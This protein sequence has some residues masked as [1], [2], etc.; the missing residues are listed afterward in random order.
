[1]GLSSRA[2]TGS[3]PCAALMVPFEVAPGEQ[4]EVVFLLGQAGTIEQVRELL[5][6]YKQTGSAGR[7]LDE[8]RRNWD[9][10]L[11]VVQVRTPDDALN[12]LLNRWLL[13]QTLSCRVWGRSAFYQSSGAYGFRDQLQDVLALA[14]AAPQLTREQILRA[15]GH[16]FVEGDV[17]HWWHPPG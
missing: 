8:A 9:Q 17:Q 16:Q 4:A 15:S 12:L 7:T 2:D 6:R 1:V 13:Y 10:V 11:G 3:D 14:V 5:A